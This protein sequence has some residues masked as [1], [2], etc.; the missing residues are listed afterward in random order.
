ML[1]VVM[2][3]VVAPLMTVVE[4]YLNRQMIEA[5]TQVRASVALL[6][7]APLGNT[8]SIETILSGRPHPRKPRGLLF[9][10]RDRM[11]LSQIIQ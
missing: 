3:N 2:L 5:K 10:P 6:A 9:L 11:V 4:G 8:T 1:I 7:L